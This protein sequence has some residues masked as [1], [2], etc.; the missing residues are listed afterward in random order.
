MAVV[1]QGCL[2]QILKWCVRNALEAMG[3][4]GHL[5]LTVVTVAHGIE[6]E[7]ADSRN[8]SQPSIRTTLATRGHAD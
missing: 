7:I 4:G 6:I 5:D 8:V 3:Q 1:P 2:S